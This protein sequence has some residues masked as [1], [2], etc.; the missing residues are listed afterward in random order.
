LTLKGGERA[1]LPQACH[2][3][4]VKDHGWFRTGSQHRDI[5]RT[6]VGEKK[7]S[8]GIFGFAGLQ[9]SKKELEELK[10]FLGKLGKIDNCCAD[11]NWNVQQEDVMGHG[12]KEPS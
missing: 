7:G 4:N 1:H 6:P 9:R 8:E 11:A 10:N 3:G 12:G 2:K 5:K